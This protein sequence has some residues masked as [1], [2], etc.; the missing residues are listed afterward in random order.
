MKQLRKGFTLTEMIMAIMLMSMIAVIIGV[1]FN[2]MFSSRELIER[3]ASIQAEMRT[4]MQ[5]VDRTIG[6]ATS[7]F[8]LDDSK[9]KGSDKGLTKEWSYIGLSEDGKKV[10]NYVWNK[11]KQGWDISD[12][13]TKSLYDMKLNLVFKTDESYK[14]NR[15]VS[16]N[17]TGKYPHSNNKFSL[18]T[19]ISALN[20]KQ[21]FSKVAKGKKGIALAYRNDPIEGQMNVAISFIF[22]TS[23]S[24]SRTMKGGYYNVKD[25]DRRY[26]ILRR[27]TEMLLDDL[28]PLGNVSVNLVEFSTTG[29][30][31]QEEFLDVASKMTDI[32]EKVNK[33]GAAGYTNPGDGL[34]YGLVSLQKN[35]AQLKYAVLLTDGVPNV[36]TIAPGH[37]EYIHIYRSGAIIPTSKNKMYK[38]N[39]PNDKAIGGGYSP[40][41]EDLSD[42]VGAKGSKANHHIVDGNKAMP[43]AVV[44][45]GHVAQKFGKGIKRINVLGFSALDEERAYGNQM[46][47]GIKTAGVDATYTD[48][49]DSEGLKKTFSD[50]KKQIEQDLWFV[51]GP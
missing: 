16:Y 13:G 28:A 9:Y 14:D 17:L 7:V 25:E 11:E 21:V 29:A 6:K 43:E 30:Y 50:I 36:R 10:R 42:V 23:G 48:V 38:E 2:T 3:E 37:G 32:K 1:I 40:Q 27:N 15:L 22:D 49:L 24:M 35:P 45:P 20:T 41:E 19:A 39:Y 46:T 4:S 47:E 12:L 8:I 31:V 44:Y 18:D 33:L 5:Y 51:S 26:S 34:R